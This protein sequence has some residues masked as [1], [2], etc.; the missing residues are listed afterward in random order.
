M[1]FDHTMQGGGGMKPPKGLAALWKRLM[2]RGADFDGAYGKI[3]LLY[4]LE[5]P[6]EMASPREQHRFDR[7]LTQL[8][9]LVLRFSLSA[10]RGGR[11]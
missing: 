11:V 3:R 5:D 4:S 7:T 1:C 2:L 6:W 9:S 8:R 10:D